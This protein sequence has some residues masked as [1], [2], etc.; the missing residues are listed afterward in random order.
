MT[1]Y[2][3]KQAPDFELV[4]QDG[5]KVRLSDFRGKKVVIFA[6]PK[7]S[8]V[9]CT[10]QACAFRDQFLRLQAHNAVI[11]GVG[12]DTPD[13]L[14]AW[15]DNHKLPYDLLYDPDRV[16]L[17]KW[18]AWGTSIDIVKLLLKIPPIKRSYWVVDENG[19]LVDMQLGIGAI[20]SVQQSLGTI[21]AAGTV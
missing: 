2:L 20:E 3:N 9:N 18:G 12:A 10:K 19:V 4:N 7:A 1:V 13:M 11:L 16:M 21:L 17:E 14:R 8:T 5:Q 15:K 6:F